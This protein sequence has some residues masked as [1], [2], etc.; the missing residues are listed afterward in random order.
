MSSW[1][2]SSM[3]STQSIKVL[4]TAAE[5]EPFYKVGGLGDYAGS[6]PIALKN[7][8]T[9]LNEDLDIRVVLPLHDPR[10][11]KTYRLEPSGSITIQGKEN[12]NTCQIYEKCFDHIQYYFI[13]QINPAL[14]S[15]AVYGKDQYRTGYKFVL[16]SIAVTKMLDQIGWQPDIIH[17]NDWHTALINHLIAGKTANKKT[18]PGSLLTIHN[19]PFMG[20][21]SE[22]IFS[23]F[24]IEPAIMEE[25]PAWA[26]ALPL[27]MGIAAAD[28]IVAVSP[29]YAEELK[30]SYFAYGLEKYFLSHS[31]KLTGIINGIDYYKW[32][33]RTDKEIAYQFSA[34]DIENRVKNKKAL[35]KEIG[36]EYNPSEPLLIVIS[37]LESQKGIDLI[38]DALS[39]TADMNW[40]AII[41][42]SGHHGYEYAFRALERI[43]PGKL[44]AVLQYDP[45]FARK[46]YASG[47]MILMP[48]LYEPCGL[49]QMIAMRYGCVPVAHAVGGLKDSISVKPE[50]KRTGF[51]FKPASKKAFVNTLSKAVENFS[52][53]ERWHQIQTNAMHSDFSWYQSAAHYAD[54]YRSLIA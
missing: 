14:E 53:K 31:H 10:T 27:P 35:Y 41:L 54:I 22:P 30:T 15:G 6:L 1:H 16:F 25:F 13:H 40:K 21:G 45:V 9:S 39:E 8:F 36:F 23:E 5:A 24:G 42:G 32:D 2:N 18:K 19:M 11:I 50:S 26:Y 46:L 3:E 48:S 12:I 7:Y 49:S 52:D 34:D 43:L 38:L 47:D 51:L 4:F 29:S 28:Q 44:H 37:R 33:P 20:Y 17:T